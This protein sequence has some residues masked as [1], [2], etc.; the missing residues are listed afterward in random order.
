MG[1]NRRDFLRISGWG[2]LAGLGGA[3]THEL[4]RPGQAFSQQYLP[5][6]KAL[7]ARRW[8]MVLDMRKCLEK[9]ERDGC[10]DCILACHT[11]HNVPEIPTPRHEIKWLWKEPYENSFTSQHHEYADEGVHG[12]PFLNLCNHCEKPPCVRVCPTQAT[13]KRED[14]IVMMDFH[15]CIGCRYCMA[16]CPY[17]SRSFN[18][19]DPRKYLDPEKMNPNYP[20][21]M[22]G[23]V[24]KCNFCAERLA[25]GLLPACVESCPVKAMIFGDLEDSESDVR[26]VLRS[27]YTIRR[28]PELGTQPEIFYI[29]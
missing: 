19:V 12:K 2:A 10:R 13:F 18:F 27:R 1:M 21:R 4:V 29:V 14:G 11:V 15:R 8:A 20:T 26:K 25:E 3:A 24:E 6:G 7:K 22:K 23:V 9:V 16:A 17:G 28:K 5:D